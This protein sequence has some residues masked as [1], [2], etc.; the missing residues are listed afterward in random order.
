M[1]LD[2]TISA[3]LTAEEYI[4]AEKRARE[5]LER[6]ISRE[7]DAD[8]ARRTPQYLNAL[9]KE[10]VEQERYT[11]YTTQRAAANGD[12]KRADVSRQQE[13]IISYVPIVPHLT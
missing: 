4:I 6:I 9:I 2:S 1:N 7:G 13:N 8:G 5:K 10:A 11:A 3:P 12:K